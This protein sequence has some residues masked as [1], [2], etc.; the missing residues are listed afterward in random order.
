MGATFVAPDNVFCPSVR[1]T[2]ISTLSLRPFSFFTVSHS[3]ISW[4]RVSV[5]S[6]FPSK[7]FVILSSSITTS[8][9][10]SAKAQVFPFGISS[11]SLL[12]W[13][14]EC[15]R[16][17]SFSST[18]FW[19]NNH[20]VSVLQLGI[21][22]G[23]FRLENLL[24]TFH[25]CSQLFHWRRRRW[26]GFMDLTLLKLLR[27]NSKHLVFLLLI[28]VAPRTSFSIKVKVITNNCS[29]YSVFLARKL[30]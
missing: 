13:T 9:S 25:L 17:Y 10:C 14:Q 5:H 12:L 20:F 11:Q 15:Q 19:A 16:S 6:K 21:Q 29:L 3:F 2:L 22:V 23:I 27:W 18:P 24:R 1:F 4:Y 30:T 8:F 28:D 26:G 7:K